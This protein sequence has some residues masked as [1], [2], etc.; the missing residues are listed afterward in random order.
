MWADRFIAISMLLSDSVLKYL[1]KK[2]A[3][4]NFLLNLFSKWLIE[5]LDE[6][7]KSKLDD[8]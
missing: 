5:T 1:Y 3:T 2:Q 7:H 6:L 8:Q 4:R